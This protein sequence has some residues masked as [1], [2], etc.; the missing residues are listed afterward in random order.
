MKRKTGKQL[1]YFMKYQLYLLCLFIISSLIAAEISAPKMEII[2]T[3]RGRA[4]SFPQGITITD[5]DTKINGTNALFWERDN[6]AQ[7]FQVVIE[8]P[9]FKITAETARYYF[10]QKKTILKTE[11]KVDSET[12]SIET[13]HLILDNRQ[14]IVYSESDIIIK[15]KTQNIEAT[16]KRAKYDFKEQIG[17]IDSQPVL[18]I[19]GQKD[20][21]AVIVQSNKMMLKNR[22]AQFFAIESINA[23]TENTILKCDS[24]VYFLKGD[25]G[26]A[27]GNPQVVDNQNRVQ[28]EIIKFFLK[29]DSASTSSLSLNTVKIINSAIAN[30]ITEDGKV[31]VWGEIFSIYYQD[32]KPTMII[33]QSDKNSLVSGKYLFTEQI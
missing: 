8:H 2:D 15:E 14:N 32:G 27:L 21:E 19:I 1:I 16:S 11:V 24:L 23:R 31:E 20:N 26:Y 28:G 13:S 22:E 33:I 18:K 29:E 6:V 5:K 17:I 30:Y 9:Q 10:D 25:S 7:I 4:T 3:E 12:L